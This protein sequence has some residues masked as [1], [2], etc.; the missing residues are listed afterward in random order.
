MTTLLGPGGKPLVAA[1]GLEDAVHEDVPPAVPNLEQ[2]DLSQEE[3]RRIA[4]YLYEHLDAIEITRQIASNANEYLAH[5][6]RLSRQRHHMATL[7][8]SGPVFKAPPALL[9]GETMEVFPCR[10]CGGLAFLKVM[11]AQG[12]YIL[13]GDAG[14]AQVDRLQWADP[15][16]REN[17]VKPRA[18]RAL[19][20]LM[21]QA[22]TP[23]EQPPL[24]VV[25]P[26]E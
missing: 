20:R 13:H 19:H 6:T 10:Y 8:R 17:V 26:G 12:A 25:K 24:R 9:D 2:E 18:L 3:W 4:L 7:G 22:K 23:T 21:E 5:V 1:T 15:Q 11:G 16:V 14:R